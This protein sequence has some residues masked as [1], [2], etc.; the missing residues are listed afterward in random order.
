MLDFR[1]K[2]KITTDIETIAMRYI[3]KAYE[4]MPKEI[5]NIAL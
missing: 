4:Q 3:E 5:L 1:A 2:H